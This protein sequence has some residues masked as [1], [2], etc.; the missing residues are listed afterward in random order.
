MIIFFILLFCFWLFYAVV[1]G[2]FSK[3]NQ[4]KN[5]AKFK[6][7]WANLK[8]DFKRDVLKQK[9][10]NTT[11]NDDLP[12]KILSQ[13]QIS[14]SQQEREKYANDLA[15]KLGTRSEVID[16]EK[17]KLQPQKDYDW[18]IYTHLPKI[19]LYR[20]I[21]KYEDAHENITIR[22]ID[23]THVYK[24]YENNKWYFDADTDDGERT[25]QSQ[26]VILLKD[27]WTSTTYK[28]SKD[29]REHILDEHY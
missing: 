4:E 27:Q 17:R 5:N 20:Y 29:V 28:T 1:T 2:Q 14:R 7:D 12:S 26:R 10:E 18:D 25:F 15:N 8:E 21:L 13:K 23:I 16:E 19:P 3:E 9:P 11:S 6:K 24:R 22:G